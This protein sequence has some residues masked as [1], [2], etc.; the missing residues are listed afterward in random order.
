MVCGGG[1]ADGGAGGDGTVVE[2]TVGLMVRL[3]GAV[4]G[5]W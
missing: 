4:V 2:L 1:A 3:M 5:W